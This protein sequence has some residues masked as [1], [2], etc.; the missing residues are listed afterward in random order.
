MT[1]SNFLSVDWQLPA[2]GSLFPKPCVHTST[3]ALDSRSFWNLGPDLISL[4]E[5]RGEGTIQSPAEP[6]MQ[7]VYSEYLL[8]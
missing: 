3:I 2:A 1:T 5:R 8:T 6:E 7:Q 4:L